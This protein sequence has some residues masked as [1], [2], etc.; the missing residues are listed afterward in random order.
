MILAVARGEDYRAAARSAGRRSGDAVSHLVA[1]SSNVEGL[2]ALAPRHGGGRPGK[3]SMTPKRPGGR[4]ARPDGCRRR[5]PMAR[6]RGASPSP[7]GFLRASAPR[8]PAGGRDIDGLAYPPRGRRQSPTR[9]DLV[10]HRD[11]PARPQGRPGAGHR[12]GCRAEKK[13]IEDAYPPRR[14]DG[15]GGSAHRPG[16]AVPG[17]APSPASRG[18]LKA[19]TPPAAT[20]MS[21][22]GPPR[23]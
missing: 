16:R 12:P 22:R 6:P 19:A 18:G 21:A 17:G 10:P 15:P 23:Y 20:N 5:R 2:D 3:T 4:S 11:G 14:G 1:R 13:L 8:R 9:P 7:R